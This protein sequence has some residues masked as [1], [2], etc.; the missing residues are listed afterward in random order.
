MRISF[1]GDYGSFDGEDDDFFRKTFHH[2]IVGDTAADEIAATGGNDDYVPEA[3]SPNA[4]LLTEL[5]LATTPAVIPRHAALR[6]FF[7]LEVLRRTC[8]RG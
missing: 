4:Q 7:D 3:W 8:G 6:G 1:G 5:K 2:E